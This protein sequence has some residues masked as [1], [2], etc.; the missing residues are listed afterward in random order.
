MNI[1]R[2]RRRTGRGETSS[3]TSMMDTMAR[4]G[5]AQT[6]SKTRRKRPPTRA[7]GYGSFPQ[8]TKEDTTKRTEDVS[9]LGLYVRVRTHKKRHP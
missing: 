4:H 9:R 8:R 1:E 5:A 6:S 7:H 3:V 2:A